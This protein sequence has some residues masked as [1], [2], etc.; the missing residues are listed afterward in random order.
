M[1]SVLRGSHD[2][3]VTQA[4]KHPGQ[5]KTGLGVAFLHSEASSG[6]C[7]FLHAQSEHRMWGTEVMSIAPDIL[8]THSCLTGR[9]LP[10]ARCF[11]MQQ[12]RHLSSYH[13]LCPQLLMSWFSVLPFPKRGRKSAGFGP[14]LSQW[15]ILYYGCLSVDYASEVNSHVA[16]LLLLWEPL[17]L[18]S[19]TSVYKI[20][21]RS[22]CPHWLL[23]VIQESSCAAISWGGWK[24]SPLSRRCLDKH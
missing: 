1:G 12:H 6:L 15:Q 14:E 11:S 8:L 24:L 10:A 7:C 17:V 22:A 16:K 21:A 9:S 20:R 13:H 3:G 18:K 23:S 19:L 2:A 5:G 4:S